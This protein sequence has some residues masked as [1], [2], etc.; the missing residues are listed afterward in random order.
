MKIIRLSSIVVV[1]KNEKSSNDIEL[2]HYDCCSALF[3][4]IENERRL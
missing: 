4:D 2:L 3:N 1:I